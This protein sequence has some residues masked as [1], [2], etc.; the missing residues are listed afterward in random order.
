MSFDKGEGVNKLLVLLY[1][2]SY[3]VLGYVE[4]LAEKRAN[5]YLLC[6][7]GFMVPRNPVLIKNTPPLIFLQN[8]LNKEFKDLRAI[9]KMKI[10]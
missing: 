8:K 3:L 4:I 7:S 5:A 2:G 9:L 6:F 10:T 1:L